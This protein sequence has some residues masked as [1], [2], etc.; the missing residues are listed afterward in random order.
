MR[1][2]AFDSRE[3]QRI[4][5]K[6]DAPGSDPLWATTDKLVIM[7]ERACGPLFSKKKYTLLK[8]LIVYS[9]NG[10]SICNQIP[11]V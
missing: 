7:T 2:V 3:A 11:T 4:F 8:V 10:E 1:E 5:T 9:N 6:S